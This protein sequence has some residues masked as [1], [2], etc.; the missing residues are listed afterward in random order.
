M[1][2]CVLH[3]LPLCVTIIFLLWVF[4]V[5]PLFTTRAQEKTKK[6]KFFPLSFK[7]VYSTFGI[8]VE[9]I[10]FV[11]RRHGQN[12]PSKHI[13]VHNQKWSSKWT[14]KKRWCVWNSALCK[15]TNGNLGRNAIKTGKEVFSKPIMAHLHR[16]WLV[17]WQ[18]DKEWKQKFF[19]WQI[20]LCDGKFSKCLRRK[21][22]RESSTSK[23]ICSQ[24]KVRHRL[25]MALNDVHFNFVYYNKD[26]K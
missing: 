23:V 3:A 21:R 9:S 19:F 25:C 11:C 15:R 4:H 14:S 22:R 10:L 6:Y 17:N 7:L 24:G 20:S 1:R 8:V 5:P 2:V 18:L 16:K 12:D 13:F 26:Q